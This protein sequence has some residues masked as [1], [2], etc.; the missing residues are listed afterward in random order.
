MEGV[1]QNH[2]GWSGQRQ[3]GLACVS[4]DYALWQKKKKKSIAGISLSRLFFMP[5]LKMRDVKPR[6]STDARWEKTSKA[7]RE[8][9]MIASSGGLMA[10]SG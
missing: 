6:R 1:G 8:Y 4:R 5:R 7:S 9:T 3:L 2:G 10:R